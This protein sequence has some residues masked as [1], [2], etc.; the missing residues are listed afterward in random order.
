[1]DPRELSESVSISGES[2]RGMFTYPV[3]PATTLLWPR[4]NRRRGTQSPTTCSH[5]TRLHVLDSDLY[6]V[7]GKNSYTPFTRY[8][9][10]YNRFD[11][12]LYRVNGAL[13]GRTGYCAAERSNEVTHRVLLT[14]DEH[15]SLA[16]KRRQLTTYT[17]THTHTHT[18]LSLIH[19]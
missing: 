18:H 16:V 6:S 14:A 2:G 10:L 15:L 4:K 13:H 7:A 12:R 19:I 1:M 9:R 3:Q 17:H 8:S 11:N 5:R